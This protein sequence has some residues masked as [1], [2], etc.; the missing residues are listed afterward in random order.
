[1]GIAEAKKLIGN[2]RKAIGELERAVF[3]DGV[4]DWA[5]AARNDLSK[6]EKFIQGEG[7]PTGEVAQPCWKEA[8]AIYEWVRRNLPGEA[9]RYN[10]IYQAALREHARPSS[11]I[12][13]HHLPPSAATFAHQVRE[14]R[15]LNGLPSHR[16]LRRQAAS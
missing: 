5:R 15:R 14:F 12:T 8:N 3:D 6:L 13:R 16:Q 11:R 1:M 7:E 2:I 9:Y 4:K 10:A